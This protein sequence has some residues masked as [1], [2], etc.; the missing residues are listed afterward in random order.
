[1]VSPAAIVTS[2]TAVTTSFVVPSPVFMMTVM[3][4]VVHIDISYV[5]VPI[6]GN[7]I[8]MASVMIINNYDSS[9][10]MPMR[11]HGSFS[12][13][14]CA[15]YKSGHQHSTRAHARRMRRATI[16]WLLQKNYL[17]RSLNLHWLLNHLNWWLV[18]LLR[19]LVVNLRRHILR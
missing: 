1:M 6:H 8:Y 15:H 3:I 9:S 2:S 7:N 13:D 17:R 12:S 18:V 5:T 11:H 14:N 19:L 16:N 4:V 10:V